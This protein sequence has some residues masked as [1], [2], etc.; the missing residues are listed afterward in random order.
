[1]IIDL[2]LLFLLIVVI[3]AWGLAMYMVVKLF[4]AKVPLVPT[5]KR[6][7]HKMIELAEISE[8]KKIYDLGSGLG[9]VLLEAEKYHPE[10]TYHGYDLLA[11]AVWWSN[12]KSKLKR[13]KAEFFCYDF[14]TQNIKDA[15]IIFC[16][17]WP[18]IMDRFYVEIYPNL[19]PGTKIISHA[20]EIKS[21]T[22]DKKEKVGRTSIY[23][24]QK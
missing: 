6:I 24:Y 7:S 15:D 4:K 17:L 14:F 13:Q 5:P 18:S 21:L 8:N 11:P 19:K 3:I 9:H 10:N 23:F 22:P 16:Y 12:Q 2:I 1:M 20:F